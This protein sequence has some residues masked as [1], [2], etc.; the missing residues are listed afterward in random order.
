MLDWVNQNILT[1]LIAL[2]LLAALVLAFFPKDSI[3]LM[4]NF[5]LLAF[6][7]EM[8]F[9]F[10]MGFHFHKGIVPYQFLV[11]VPWIPLWNIHYR[12]A[13]DGVSL[14]LIVMTCVLSP[15]A[16]MGTWHSVEKNIK[17]Y[18]I[19][20]LVLHAGM[21]GVFAAMDVFL[22][23]VFWEIMLVPMYFLIGIW[24]GENRVYATLKFF[25]YTM[26]GSV[27]MLVALLYL[28]FAAGRSFNFFELY[29]IQLTFNEQCWLFAALALAFAVKIPLFPLHTWLPDA[30]VQAPTFGSVILAGVL[31]KMGAYGFF[32]FA[33]PLFPDAA[34][35][36]QP[37]LMGLA[38]FGVVYGALVAMVQSDIKK[39]VAYS[40]VSHMGVVMLGLFSLN[41]TAMTGGLY[42]MFAHAVSTGSL[43][44][45]IGMLYDRTH[46]RQISDYS[47]LAKIMPIFTV[48]FIIVTM[49]SIAVPLTN[50]FV[51][52]FLALTGSFLVSQKM[53][54]VA[55]SGVVLGAVTMLWLVERVFFGKVKMTQ[56]LG[57]DLNGRE[58]FV[59]IV[60]VFFIFWMG[61]YPKVF[62]GRIS[63]SLESVLSK[64]EPSEEN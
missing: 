15:L 27:L 39:L 18:L 41:P 63:G 19:A 21:V 64:I 9:S 24:G 57:L 45:L 6:L 60:M 22:F 11:D 30:H 31:L 23:Y 48:F 44:L 37:Y 49:S 25:I 52:E 5:A 38:A 2:P 42:Q 54:I 12:V 1:L 26:A 36:L 35:Y 33:L 53:A 34:V 28:Y 20:I 43:F 56:G 50:G 8:I 29:D 7:F 46:T 16:L 51:G 14:L 61:I 4:K 40:S 59:M 55:A 32:R 47:G 17:G 62:L 13:V 58:S 10:H 3:S